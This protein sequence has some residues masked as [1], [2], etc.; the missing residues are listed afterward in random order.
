MTLDFKKK[1]TCSTNRQEKM[2]AK[3]LQRLIIKDLMPLSVF[4]LSGLSNQLEDPKSVIAFPQGSELLS[5]PHS[6]T[7]PS[8]T[9]TH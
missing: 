1:K 6:T 9:T 8:T 3:Q 2:N 5:A 4:L 7:T